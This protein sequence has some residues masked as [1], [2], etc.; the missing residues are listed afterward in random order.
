MKK[1]V[2]LG[3]MTVAVLL[4][5]GQAFAVPV[6]VSGSN[7]ETTLQGVLDGITVGGDSS[8][9][10]TTDQM[11]PSAYWSV[12][13][14]GGSF[15]QI[16]IEIA[17]NAGSNTFGIFDAANPGNQVEL[18][19]GADSMGDS[20]TFGF[21]NGGGVWTSNTNNVVGS[22]FGGNLF[23]FY[24]DTPNGLFFSDSS[25]NSDDAAHMVGYR[26]GN[27]DTVQIADSMPGLWGVNEYIFGWEDE[28]A[29]DWDWDYNDMVVV[30]ESMTAVAVPAP[31]VL[32]FALVGLSLIGF[33]VVVRRRADKGYDTM[34]A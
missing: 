16:V 8:V 7:G 31:G 34:P 9:N 27:G 15:S 14:S 18:Y 32:G 1:L 22:G 2:N 17:G 3:I 23:G 19:S 4:F 26:G 24:L 29:P 13:G 30:V 12:N 21:L 6:N 5:G 28:A 10:V 25:L 11:S 20:A 33:G